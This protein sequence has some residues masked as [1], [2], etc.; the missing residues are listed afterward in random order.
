MAPHADRASGDVEA[1]S[2]PRNGI[3]SQI[4]DSEPSRLE[5]TLPLRSQL[6]ELY[7]DNIA[8]KIIKTAVN[9]L[10][11]NNP[12][13]AYPE[14]VLQSGPEA[15]KYHL[16]EA[17]FWTCGF[18]PGSIYSLVERLVKYPQTVPGQQKQQLLQKLLTLGDAWAEP[19]HAMARRT[20]T[21]DMSFMIQPSM[22]VRWEVLHDQRA[23]D[24]IIT[25]ARS[26]HT[27]NNKTVN[28]IRSWDVLDQKGVDISSATEDFLVIIDSMCNLDLLYYAAAQTGET[29]LADAA[30]AHAKTLIR[31][32]LRPEKD[33]RGN[34]KL[35]SHF[36]VVNFDPRSGDIKDRRTGQGYEAKS[37]WARGQ[38][39]GI[40]G[41]AQTYLWTTD[42]EFL[43]TS[44]AMAEYF[45]M[46]LEL[47]PS[48]VELSVPGENRKRG[49]YVP[50][51]DFDAPI[52]DES[53]P[54]RDSSAGVIAANGMLILSQALAGLR[55]FEES[56]RF[57]DMAITIIKD[58]LDFSL[59][60]QKTKT[61]Y[62]DGAVSTEEVEAGSRFD[63]ILRNATANYNAKDHKRYWDHG[64][65]YGDYYLI[66]FG[67]RLLRMG[68]L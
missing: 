25:A 24:A 33:P 2:A 68:L 21:H 51:W 42:V 14:Y 67:N 29:Q 8:A 66:E 16:R 52:L 53:N 48:V 58:T 7:E 28:A 46:R 6:F 15:G 63:A 17:N 65:V 64:L 37:T 26:L 1:D 5:S 12:P 27:R 30:T 23:L 20:D 56:K 4:V 35:F 34:K 54:L 45:I 50:L 31:S 41:Y 57:Q 59:S 60:Q 19:I 10:V 32:H 49:R 55:R 47:S 18:F 62:A 40:M 43:E 9:G 38:A 22:R 39:W 3:K 13:A 44:I 11:D 36:H 61:V